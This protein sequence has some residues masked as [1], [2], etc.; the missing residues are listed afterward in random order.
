MHYLL[1]AINI[2]ELLFSGVDTKTALSICDPERRGDAELFK[3]VV[4]F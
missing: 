4:T 1:S 2:S 3:P